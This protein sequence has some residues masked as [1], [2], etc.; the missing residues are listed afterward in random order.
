MAVQSATTGS[1]ANAQNIV[2]TNCVYT[3]EHSHPCYNAVTHFKLGQGNKTLTYPKV[4]QMTAE[5]LTDGNDLVNS[6]DIGLTSIDLTPSEV[7]LK[8]IL[9][10]KL[11][12]QF[13]EDVF[14]VIGRQM[15]D[16]MSRKKDRDIIALF[17]ALNGGTTL[18]A[19]GATLGTVQI[20]GLAAWA[21][22]N[23][24]PRPIF[25]IHHPNCVAQLTKGTM[26]VGTTY[27]G[28]VLD[29][30][31]KGLLKDFWKLAWDG[32]SVLEDGEIDA[33][34]GYGSGYGAIFSREAMACITSLEVTSKTETDISLRGTEVVIVSD[35]GVFEID[36]TYGAPVQYEIGTLD[37]S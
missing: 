30:I 25:V 35:Y 17:A 4:G 9:T 10:D 26:A 18:G 3:A 36:D 33:I 31:S 16:A 13:N 20:S 12:R 11:V 37:T 34:S 32:I 27:W 22:T 23:K 21:R 8:V 24:L 14:K 2:I 28:G 7:G 1:L 5:A 19:D 6:E 29:D 15:G